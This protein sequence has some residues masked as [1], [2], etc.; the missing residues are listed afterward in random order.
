MP[1]P[2]RS[3]SGRIARSVPGRS[4]SATWELEVDASSGV[5][6]PAW[7]VAAGP[8]PEPDAILIARFGRLTDQKGSTLVAASV[9][10]LLEHPGTRPVVPATGDVRI[11]EALAGI[12][13]AATGRAAVPIGFDEGLAHRIETSADLFLIPSPYEPCGLNQRYS[14]R[15]GIVPLVRRARGPCRL[16]RPRRWRALTRVERAGSVIRSWRCGDGRTRCRSTARRAMHGEQALELDQ[17]LPAA[18]R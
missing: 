10:S 17:V 14:M 13:R 5:G 1:G 16:F 8:E 3:C 18:A 7:R 11:A 9:P 6:V 12:E 2:T 4:L 15:Y